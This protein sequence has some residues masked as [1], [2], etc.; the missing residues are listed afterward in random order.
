MGLWRLA[1]R[2]CG[3]DA[4][5]LTVFQVEVSATSQSL[6]W[7]SLTECGVSECDLENSTMRRPRPTS[8]V[9]PLQKWKIKYI[10]VYLKWLT[11]SDWILKKSKYILAHYVA[12]LILIFHLVLACKFREWGQ[13]RCLP[14]PF[15][16]IIHGPS[17]VSYLCY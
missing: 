7:R 17:P 3:F 12:R 14:Y 2:C 1:W 6:S 8:D 9:E 10:T 16:L 11:E 5:L 4:F 15:R 13:Y